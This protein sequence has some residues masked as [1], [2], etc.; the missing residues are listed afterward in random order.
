MI[1]GKQAYVFVTRGG[2]HAGASDT[3]TPYL[4]QFLGFIG[5]KDVEFVYAEGL[6]YGEEVRE[7]SL[8]SAHQAI[9]NLLVPQAIAA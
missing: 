5:I 2:I 7:K 8:N 1:A 3:Q 4:R 6:A 9:A